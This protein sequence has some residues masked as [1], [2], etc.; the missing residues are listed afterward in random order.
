[1]AE[2]AV[3]DVERLMADVRARVAEKRARRAYGEDP[4]A[5]EF[6]LALD[7]S[8]LA[9]LSRLAV[10]AGRRDTMEATGR[11]G[12]V[13]T[14]ARRATVKAISPFLS[15]ILAQVNSYNAALVAHLREL[16]DGHEREL[17]RERDRRV[18][19]EA[20]VAELERRVE[21]GG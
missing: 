20:R 19:L 9:R 2:W 15:D 16:Q 12:P 18:A 1:M 14:L 5:V 7:E 17:E 10:I 11:L 21:T 8:P 13:I 3:I 4:A 6:A